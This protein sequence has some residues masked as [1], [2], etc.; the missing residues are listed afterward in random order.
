LTHH[1]EQV[2]HFFVSMMQLLEFRVP[3]V[4]QNKF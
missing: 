2:T 3:Q 4:K 1:L